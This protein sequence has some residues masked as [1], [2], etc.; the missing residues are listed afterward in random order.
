MTGRR[1]SIAEALVEAL[2]EADE[3]VKR[4]LAEQLRPYL[5]DDPE[6][7]CGAEEKAIQLGLNREVLVRMARQG[8][9]PSARKIGR[10]WRFP[11]DACEVD[12]PHAPRLS[13]AALPLRPLRAV[14]AT[15]ADAIRGRG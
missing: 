4:K 10:E 8:R 3:S 11:A 1:T 6:R 7:L 13:A 5:K 2:G 14:T 12:P 15:A 9:V